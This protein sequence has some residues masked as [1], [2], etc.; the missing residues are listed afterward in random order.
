MFLNIRGANFLLRDELVEELDA[1][2]DDIEQIWPERSAQ[3]K[4]L[5]FLHV[6]SAFLQSRDYFNADKSS[7]R[8]K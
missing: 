8:S 5:L 1:L 4:K 6:L 7:E 3:T 2:A